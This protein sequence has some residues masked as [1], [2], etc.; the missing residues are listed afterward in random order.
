MLSESDQHALQ[1]W[2]RRIGL[3]STVSEVVP[4]TG[5]SQNIVVRLLVDGRPMVLRRPP[6]HPRPTSDN[7]MRR[8]IAV[9]TTLKGTTVPHPAFI[10]GCEDPRRARRGVLPDGGRRRIQPRHRGRRRLRAQ[11]RDAPPGGLSYAASLAQL[12]RCPG[13][14]APRRIKRPGSFLARQVPQF[15]RL[16]ES[17][18]HDNY[19]PESFPP[20]HA[21]ADWLRAAGPR[22]RTRNH[23]RRRT[24]EQRV[25]APRHPELAAFIDWEM[26]AV[27]IR[28]WT[29]AG[30]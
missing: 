11:S 17:Y 18:R 25:A 29:W 4:L 30:C 27:G 13:R 3:G 14:A 12:G 7:T 15:M 8:E 16:L 28:C 21:L 2:V 22:R 20:M 26:Y 5:G 23:A 10:A 19:A 9:L 24:P 1:G 6:E